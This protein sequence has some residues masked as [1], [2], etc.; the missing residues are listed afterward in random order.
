MDGVGMCRPIVWAVKLSNK[1]IMTLKYFVIFDGCC[2]MYSYATTNQQ[3][4]V[5]MEEEVE[6]SWDW[7]RSAGGANTLF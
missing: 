6:R 3:H 2:L 7:G 1:K 5:V 4:A